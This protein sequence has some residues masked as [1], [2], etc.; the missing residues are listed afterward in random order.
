MTGWFLRNP[1]AANLL[2]A[3]ILFLGIQTVMS[4]RI[5]G[6]PRIP[7][8]VIEITT[9]VPNATADQIDSQVTRRIERALEGL[10]GV[11]SVRSRSGDELSIIV[12]R[13]TAAK[14]LE[15]LLD[16]VRIRVDSV[17][18]LPARAER[19]VIQAAPFDLP[20]LYINLHGDV[21]LLTQQRLARD[22]RVALLEQPELSRITSWG[23]LP[24][25]MR[26]EIDPLQLQRM[27]MTVEDVS[28]LI[29][30]RS[31]AFQAGSLRTAGGTVFLR[32]DSQALFSAD[33]AALPIIE[34]ADGRN[35]RLGDIATISEGFK[36]E[37]LLFR[38]DG[39]P[40]VGMEVLVGRKENLL[41]IS[42]VVHETVAAFEPRLPDAAKI[43]IWGDSST[44]ISER[45]ALLRS[46]GVQGLVLVV[47]LLS[48]FLDVRLAFWVAMGIPIS[49][50]GALAVAGTRWV[51]YS[52][53]DVTTFG[54]II[55]LGILVDDAV[56]VGESVYEARK[57]N[58][59]PVAATEAGVHK[60]TLATVFGVFT[61]IA[62]F[63]PM[64]L[65]ENQLGK[66]L[67]SFSGIVILALIFSLIES[68]L[69]LPAHLAQLRLN[70]QPRILPMRLWARVQNVARGGLIGFRDGP[71]RAILRVALVHR[72]AVVIGFTALAVLG[73]GLIAKGRIASVFFPEVPGQIITIGMEMD[74]RAPFALTRANLERI[75][76]AGVALNAELAQQHGLAEPPIRSVF[77]LIENAQSATLYAELTS[78]AAR[79]DLSAASI[80]QDWQKRVG[81][82][83]GTTELQFTA[84]EEL[85][86]GFSL[87]LQGKDPDALRAASA[88]VRAALAAISGVS[89]IRDTLAGGQPQI[90]LRLRAEAIG[91]GITPETLAR[92]IGTRFGGAEV[93]KIQRDGREMKVILRL[94]DNARNEIG[95]V[96][97]ARIRSES[98]AWLPLSSV[99]EVEGRYVSNAIRRFNGKLTNTIAASIDRSVVAPEEVAQAIFHGVG[100]EIGTRYPGVTL[101][102]GGE[103]EEIGEIQGGLKRALALAVVLIYVLMAVPLRSYG[104]PFLILAIIPFGFLGAAAGHLIMDLPLSVFSFFGMLALAGVVVNDSL[105]MLTRYQD[106]R[107]AGVA[108]ATAA[109]E[110]ATSRLQAI[111]LTTATTVIGLLPLLTETSEQ[112]QYLI[113][114][115]ASLAFGE[116]FST[117]LLLVLMPCLLLIA[118]DT[119]K[120]FG[121]GR[122]ALDPAP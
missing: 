103:L 12:V 117:A 21:D 107:A 37:D 54:L 48:L 67:A 11:R 93:Q 81:R 112:A 55:A 50:A 18:S 25:E 14:K 53:N 102:G 98:G 100:A 58:S 38:F 122:S 118:D 64:L 8:E 89:N 3:L 62:A 36:T 19:P 60:V 95:D 34:R 44:Y 51:D 101:K 65:I 79:P 16:A 73:L 31:L 76:T 108:A 13:K 94:D 28:A 85:A 15:D 82:L 80:V 39:A 92:Q 23:I 87:R 75:E 52:L 1:V 46:N 97:A 91:L 7:S 47:I 111:F 119:G 116:L 84:S 30:E 86:G 121:R 69:I 49:M 90:S 63:F 83:E 42:R 22:L 114:A 99:A 88:E 68:K 113:P 110:A 40:T 45:L 59:D 6:F 96:M 5:E 57:E 72:Y 17:E 20:A 106:L 71:Y 104:L 105:V 10:D 70:D 43:T 32:A 77:F 78:P 9:T 41:K 4:I 56:V 66:V 24:R 33:F 74:A 61:T 120:L 29:R 27:G 26:I 35:V 115:A 109:H 2:M